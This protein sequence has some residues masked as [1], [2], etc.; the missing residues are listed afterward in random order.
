MVEP[1][2]AIVMELMEGGTLSDLLCSKDIE[3][4][5]SVRLAMA[6]DIAMGIQVL[7]SHHPRNVCPYSIYLFIFRI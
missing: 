4:P 1:N 6:K 2:F 5:W 7:H 3:L